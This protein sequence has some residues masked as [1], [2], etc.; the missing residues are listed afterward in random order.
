MILIKYVHNKGWQ[1]LYNVGIMGFVE[2]NGVFE[3]SFLSESKITKKNFRFQILIIFEDG[4]AV[5]VK[6]RFTLH[7]L[8]NG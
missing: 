4:V 6:V 2:K 3:Y 8:N 7:H 5:V 1:K